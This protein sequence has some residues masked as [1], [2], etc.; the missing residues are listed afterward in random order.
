MSSSIR[1]FIAVLFLVCGTALFPDIKLHGLFSDNMVMQ[2]DI[3]V[4]VYGIADEGEKVTVEING[5]KVEAVTGAEGTWKVMLKPMKAGGPF[6]MTVKGNN[7]I[8]LKNILIGDVWICTGQSNMQTSIKYYRTYENGI[9]TMFAD[10]PGDY[11]NTM[12][13]LFKVNTG[14]ADVPRLNVVK[15]R[16]YNGWCEAAGAYIDDFSATGFFF[17][18]RLAAESGV[19]IGLIMSTVGGTDAESWVSPDVLEAKPDYAPYLANYA[20]AVSNY[21]AAYIRFTNEMAAW[22]EK[23]KAGVK[24]LPRP[25]TEPMGTNNLKRPSGLYHYML[26]PLQGFAIRGAIW[27]QGENNAGRFS[28]YRAIMTDLIQS[29]RAQWGIPNFPFYYVQLAGYMSMNSN[30]EDPS[31]AYLREA[32][33][34]TLALTNTGMA[35]ALDGGLEKNIHPP[36]KELVGNRLA[37]LALANVYGKKIVPSGPMFRSFKV[38]GDKAIVTFSGIGGGLIASNVTLDSYELTSGKL[39]GFAVCGADKKFK[40]ADAV[41]KGDSVICT[42]KEVSKPINIRYAWANFPLAN[43]YNKE[44]FPA[45]PFRTDTYAPGEVLKVGGIAMGKPFV[46]SHPNSSQYAIGSYG[47]LTDGLLDDNA[48]T[49]FSTDGSMTFP[50]N[51]TIDLKGSFTVDTIRVYNSA[52]GGTK[53]VSVQVSSDGASFTEVGKTEF[54]NYTM[55]VYEL[56]GLSLKNVSQVRI[57]FENVHEISI[58]KKVNGFVLIREL[59]V[60]GIP[61][62]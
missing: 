11:S 34:E 6:T 59:E 25:P 4:A 20:S 9:F 31:W 39:S 55:D 50:K 29:W 13:R 60:Q 49:I 2:R 5:Q 42:S 52:Q 54:K 26:A 30:T 27:Y 19:P 44:G 16:A 8:T 15:D 17:G 38:D 3:A 56:K 24:D 28:S 53:N 18:K 62:K 35:L 43:L 33:T 10:I 23:R 61:G 40:W 57:V 22:N 48:R 46:C 7:T 37:A 58:W 47:G 1:P 41:I 51:V 12:L 32:Q 45:V 36:Y 21:P 14:A